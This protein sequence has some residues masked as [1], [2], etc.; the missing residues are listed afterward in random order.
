MD[1]LQ[2]LIFMEIPASTPPYSSSVQELTRSL[3]RRSRERVP[4]LSCGAETG[5]RQPL[6]LPGSQACVSLVTR[7]TGAG[8]TCVCVGRVLKTSW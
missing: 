2:A 6:P 5:K 7:T 4:H 8:Q 1:S 3:T